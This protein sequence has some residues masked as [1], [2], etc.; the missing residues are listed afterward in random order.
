MKEN[1]DLLFEKIEERVHVLINKKMSELSVAIDNLFESYRKNFVLFCDQALKD[2]LD[3]IQKE[4]YEKALACIV[5]KSSIER[6]FPEEII[7]CFKNDAIEDLKKLYITLSRDLKNSHFVV[8]ENNEYSEHP[9]ITIRIKKNK[10][11]LSDK[12]K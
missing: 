6:Y 2:K 5:T 8:R 10:K 7:K 3:H 12:E 9:Y 1:N 11:K 4:L